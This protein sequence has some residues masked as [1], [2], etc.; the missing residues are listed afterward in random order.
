M[1]GL[2]G[3]WPPSRTQ[4]DGVSIGD[5]WKC[6][7]LPQSPPAKP[8]ESIAP[9]HKLTQWLCYS[10]MVPMTRLMKI[11]FAGSD[12]LT[13]LPEYR[14]G[15]LLIDMGLLTLKEKDL[16]RGLEA[17]RENAQIKGQPNME[18]VPLFTADDDV[19]VEWR[20]ATVG[21]LD[22][23]LEEVNH[24]L[25]LRGEE[26]LSLA[27]LLEAGTWKVRSVI[28]QLSTT[29]ILTNSISRAGVKLLKSR[30]QTP[31]NHR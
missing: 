2:A 25:G 21:F 23:L 16:Q 3:I 24:Q 11:H 19:V 17:Y 9:F 14:N 7:V 29:L 31:K 15:G 4:I 10:I 28:H 20:A 8:W 30:D 22:D 1:D 18:V 27:Q 26:A 5:A 12:L 13:G 6:S